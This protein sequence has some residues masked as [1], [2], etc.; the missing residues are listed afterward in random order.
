[1]RSKNQVI[2]QFLFLSLAIGLGF[3]SCNP[4]KETVA[5]RNMQNLTAHFNILYN[6]NEI[7]NESERN[8]QLAHSDDYDRIISVFK[9][10][11]ES[12]SQG[13]LSKLDQAI[14]KA[15]TIANEKSQSKYVDEAYFLIGKANHLKSNFFNAVEYFDYVYLNYPK[16]KE[17]KQASLAWKTRSLIAS[18][19]LE[20][21]YNSIDSALK[22]VNTEKKSVADIFAIR[23]QL[24]IYAEEDLQAINMIE[25][26]IASKTSKQNKIRWTYLLA[27][28]Q[29]INGQAE[30]AYKNYARVLKSNASFEMAFNAKL[31]SINLKNKISLDP[32]NRTKQIAALLKDSKNIDFHDQIYFQIANSY[33]EENDIEKAIENYNNAISKSTKNVIQKGLAY[34][35]LAEIYFNDS[36][37]IKSKA[38]YDSTLVA[39]PSIYPDYAQIK[40]KADNIELLADRLSIIAKEDTLQMLAKLPENERNKKINTLAEQELIKAQAKIDND[41]SGVTTAGTT[42]SSGGNTKFYFNNSIAINQGIVDFKKTWGTRK[43]EDNWRR[44]QKSAADISNTLANNQVPINDPFKEITAPSA[45]VNIDSLKKALIGSIPLSEEMKKVSNEKIGSAMYDIGNYYREVTNDTLEAINTYEKLLQRF[46]EDPNKLAVYYNLYRLYKAANM[47]LSDKYKNIL[48]DQFPESPFA[49]IILDPDYNQKND[50]KEMAFNQFYNDVFDLYTAKKYSDVLKSIEKNSNKLGDEKIPAQLAYLNSLALGHLE[51]LDKL[52][53]SFKSIVD[54]HPE[55]QLI[56]PLIKLQLAFIDSNRT[57]IANRPFALL[58]NETIIN[59]VI[60]EP[61]NQE[62]MINKPVIVEAVVEKPVVVENPVAVEK[63]IVVT[64]PAQ[65]EEKKAEEP[66]KI[67][68]EEPKN[69]KPEVLVV[70]EPKKEDPKIKIEPI[71]TFFEL[72]EPGDYY[73]IVNVS[74]PTLNLSSS[75]F[76]IGQFNRVNFSGNSIKHQVKSIADQNQLIFVGPLNSKDAAQAYF[77][78]I[79]PLMKEIMKIPGSAYNTF[80]ISEK[81][82][83]KITDVEILQRY[84]NFYEKNFKK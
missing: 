17:V 42:S 38:Y 59:L 76:G 46:P 26:A 1:M 6:A 14:L 18:D 52:E 79:N 47:Q 74:D 60:E 35:K 28:L 29:Q 34:L 45:S 11:N 41:Q 84:V 9:E 73:F 81:N 61:T 24:H 77:D 23:A 65:S 53:D 2:R 22:Y 10:T 72:N 66:L 62:P 83:E 40:K 37:Y 56:V 69:T 78:Q 49:K 4:Q 13:E 25:K 36:D 50:E 64:K 3:S 39:L 12:N 31:S 8:I 43:L 19:R 58:D 55:D 48:L 51:K 5:S 63:P 54:S 30:D 57:E 16:E 70:Q 21:A 68:V 44:S 71:D 80:L 82:L 32:Q 75:R 33:V 20:E 15:N 67:V 7:V 27:Q